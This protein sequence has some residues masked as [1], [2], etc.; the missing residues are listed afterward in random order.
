MLRRDGNAG[1]VLPQ[2]IRDLQ[3]SG[4]RS[5]I[6]TEKLP[7]AAVPDPS[8]NRGGAGG[9]HRYPETGK[10]PLHGLDIPRIMLFPFQEKLQ[11]RHPIEYDSNRWEKKAPRY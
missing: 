11:A 8:R 9:A 7:E 4:G 5:G 6:R 3:D 10:E 2:R 1:Y